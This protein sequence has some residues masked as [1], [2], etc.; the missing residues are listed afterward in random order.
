MSSSTMIHG[1]TSLRARAYRIPAETMTRPATQAQAG[2]ARTTAAARCRGSG[3]A[4]AST[5]KAD[6]V[7]VHRHLE[8][9][10]VGQ[11]AE[12]ADVADDERLAE[13]E[14]ADHRAGGLAH[15][16]R[17][18]AH[19]HVAGGH[20]RPEPRLVHVF[21]TDHALAFEPALEQ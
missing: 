6:L 2:T 3:F 4:R 5:A 7:F 18:K 10:L 9:D 11:L 21:L 19:V 17:A 13:R 16:R 14:R 8:G 12:P 15:R 1:A 20:Q